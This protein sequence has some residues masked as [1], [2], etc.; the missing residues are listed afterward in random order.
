MEEVGAQRREFAIQAKPA[1]RFFGSLGNQ[2]RKGAAAPHPCAERGVI[3]LTT[4]T[5]LQLGDHFSGSIRHVFVQPLA[6]E[7]FDLK[8]HAQHDVAGRLG[9]GFGCGFEDRFD[10]MIGE[11]GNDGCH[12][13]AGGNAG[14]AE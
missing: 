9:A 10:L 7:I 1:R 4:A 5:V 13:D 12:H 11:P 2:I 6:G 3:V 8:R 14:A